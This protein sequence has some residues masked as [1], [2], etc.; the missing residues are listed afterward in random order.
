MT[1]R[2]VKLKIPDV[3]TAQNQERVT[4]DLHDLMLKT[5]HHHLVDNPNVTDLMDI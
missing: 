5:L 1:E 4:V 2:G 3:L